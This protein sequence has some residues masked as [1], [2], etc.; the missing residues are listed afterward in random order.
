MI[1]GGIRNTC[2]CQIRLLSLP[3]MRANSTSTYYTYYTA[4]KDHLWGP[5]GWYD[6]VDKNTYNK[7]QSQ[8]QKR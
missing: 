4:T 3:V 1:A 8:T 7:Q 5:F 2:E 6:N